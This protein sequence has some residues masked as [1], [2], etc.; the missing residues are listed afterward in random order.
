MKK[1]NTFLRAFALLLIATLLFPALLGPTAVYADEGETWVPP[2]PASY[3]VLDP[4][5]MR[6]IV[7]DY[8]KTWGLNKG[9]LSI[10]Y[11]YLDTGDSWFYNGDTWTYS[12]DLYKV[13]LMMILAG[14]EA[15]GS[16]SQDTVLKGL[17]LQQ[18]EQYTLIY[19]STVY[20]KDMMTAIGTPEECREEYAKFTE[21]PEEYFP[22]NYYS[23]GYFSARVMTQ[24]MA[25]L[26]NNSESY[27]HIIEILELCDQD[28]YFNNAL[29]DQYDVAQ[30]FGTFSDKAG[31]DYN[32]CAGIIYTPHP[33]VLVVMTEGMGT[34]QQVLKDMC[35]RFTDYTKSLDGAYEDWLL[36]KDDP[37]PT[38]VPTVEPTAEPAVTETTAPETE[39]AAPETETAAEPA[40]TEGETVVEA[41]AEEPAEEPAPE[42]EEKP[43]KTDAE[44]AVTRRIV[45]IVF[46]AALC[47]ILL[48]GSIVR[49][50]LRRKD[51]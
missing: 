19:N 9:T 38:P 6:A 25:E 3:G 45:L 41:P 27:P 49:A 21:L 7:D 33:F 12:A 51:R 2:E 16:I 39:T 46:A 30:K 18:A 10:G 43:A 29:N 22:E 34:K 50:M 17:T 35:T 26:A 15:Q 47:V 11:Q 23:D 31:V 32:H 42:K 44:Q 14:W 36:H 1:R 5:A 24:I 40:Q 4:D 48:L 20:A 28:K 37:V 13:P 8:I